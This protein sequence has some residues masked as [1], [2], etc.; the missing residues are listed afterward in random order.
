MFDWLG[1]ALNRGPD[2]VAV[3]WLDDAPRL[4]G[5]RRLVVFCSVVG[6]LGLGLA[7]SML[8]AWCW[9]VWRRL[10]GGRCWCCGRG[11]FRKG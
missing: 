2:W 11:A 7:G 4:E 10:S 3:E 8:A 6:G 1:W 5:L 9:C